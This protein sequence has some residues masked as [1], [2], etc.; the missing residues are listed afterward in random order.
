MATVESA[1]RQ[2]QGNTRIFPA[3]P[4]PIT[5]KCGKVLRW[6]WVEPILNPI[7]G[8]P[9]FWTNRWENPGEIC[10]ECEDVRADE[11]AKMRRNEEIA[12]KEKW[13]KNLDDSIVAE[14]G[15]GVSKNWTFDRFIPK[16]DSQKIAL[17]YAKEAADISA[18]VYLW[19]KSTGTGKSHLAGSAYRHARYKNGVSGSFWKTPSL[20]RY[21][22]V[23]E[24][25]EQEARISKCVKDKILVIDDLGIGNVTDFSIQVLYEI[26]D[27]RWLN[28]SKGLIITAN[29]SLD[30]L[31]KKLEDDRLTS[32][33]AG[34]CKIVEIK[35]DDRRM[36]K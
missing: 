28:E 10:C 31:A 30:D 5:C 29:L 7:N 33:L 27:G 35:G 18:N 36:D 17:A 3:E 13:L 8:N 9:F 20:I 23:I 1:Q 22:R 16:S 11:I 2:Y 12:R 4:D 32:R 14:M 34:M 26:I 24:S 21:M 19:G 15:G 25:E 6:K